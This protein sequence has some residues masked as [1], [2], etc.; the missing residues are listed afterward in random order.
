M[1]TQTSQNSSQNAAV[2][3]ALASNSEI[4]VGTSVVY[5]LH[6][7]C[8]VMAIETRELAGATQKFYK[9]EVQKSPLSRTTRHEPAIWVPVSTA[10][11]RGIRAP[12]SLEDVEAAFAI[13]SSREY[14]LPTND[15]WAT[16]QNKIESLVR[17]EGSMGIAKAL[18]FL[19]V[20]KKKQVVPY[21]EVNRINETLQRQFSKEASDLLGETMKAIDERIAKSMKNKLLA[22]S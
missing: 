15:S 20:L 6:G 10:K 12:M 16:T 1:E 5:G 7:K 8:T 14:Y 19:F 9:L 17:A 2:N 4:P 13:L 18:S 21:P 11:N 22:D 3:A